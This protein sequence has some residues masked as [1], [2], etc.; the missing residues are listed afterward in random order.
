[1]V[2][3]PSSPTYSLS[4][5]MEQAKHSGIARHNR[6]GVFFRYPRQLQQ[7]IS[8]DDIRKVLLFCETVNIPGHNYLSATVRTF[9]EIREAPYEKF[10]N[11]INMTFYVDSDMRVKHLFDDWA[12]AIQNPETRRFGYYDNY[13]T[14][15][16]IMVYNMAENEV[17]RVV[18]Y[19]CYPKEMMMVN[20]DTTSKDIMRLQISMQIKY[21][22]STPVQHVLDLRKFVPSPGLLSF[23]G[24]NY[25]TFQDGFNNFVNT[26]STS[27]KLSLLGSFPGLDGLA[28]DTQ[29]F[30]TGANRYVDAFTG[31]RQRIDS[32]SDAARSNFASFV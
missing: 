12:K 14:D 18:C 5:F 23:F 25:D 32:F 17:Y 22:S 15:I 28:A 13:T 7:Q 1:M 16:H 26:G 31:E 4:R 24:S 11:P 3:E 20:M 6:F 21:W 29:G 10:Y 8:H 30:V 19:E 2:A 27:S 9:G